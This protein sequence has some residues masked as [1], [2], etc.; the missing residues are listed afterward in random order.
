MN[1][2]GTS[3]DCSSCGV[4]DPKVIG[5][6][7]HDCPDCE[8]SLDRDHNVAINIQQRAVGHTVQALRG[9]RDTEPMKREA[10]AVA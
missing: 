1:L 8:C 4:T 7:S 2:N 5:D 6:R 9:D 10:R 3:Q